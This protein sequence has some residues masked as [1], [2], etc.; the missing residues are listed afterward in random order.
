MTVRDPAAIAHHRA[1]PYLVRHEICALRPG[2]GFG[3]LIG[4]S[5]S[6]ADMSASTDADDADLPPIHPLKL[7]ARANALFERIRDAGVDKSR[8]REFL[9]SHYASLILLRFFNPAVQSL[10]GLQQASELKN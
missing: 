10:R 3:L 4:Y 6:R 7:V 9:Y 1:C 8:N 5:L 2:A